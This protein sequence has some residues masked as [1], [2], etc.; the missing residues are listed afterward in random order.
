MKIKISDD[1]IGCGACASICPEV[2]EM[3]G[4]KSKVKEQKDIPCVDE[5]IESCPVGAIS[6]E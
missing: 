6:K 1:C 3:D 2:F 5:A 4:L